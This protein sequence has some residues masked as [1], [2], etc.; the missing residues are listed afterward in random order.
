MLEKMAAACWEENRAMQALIREQ[1]EAL[2][3]L[4]DKIAKN[5]AETADAGKAGQND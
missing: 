2:G 1:N 4:A 5:K 3:I